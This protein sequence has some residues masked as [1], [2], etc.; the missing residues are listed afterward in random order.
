MPHHYV[1]SVCLVALCWGTLLPADEYKSAREAYSVGAAFYNAGSYAKS[2][3]PF[4]AAIA[5]DEEVKFRVDCYRA[6]IASYRLLEKGD[7]MTTAVEYILIHSE[8]P[9]EKSLTQRSYLSFLHQRGLTE[10]AVKRYEERLKTKP[11]DVIAISILADIYG[12]LNENPARAAELTKQ[13]QKL[14]PADPKDPLTVLKQAELA[15]QLFKAKKYKEAAELYENIAPLDPKLAAWHLKEA[16]SCW[17][18]E[19]DLVRAKEDALA[20]AKSEPE[21]RNDQLTYFWSRNLA[22]I[23]VTTGEFELAVKHYELALTK[24]TI[25]GY[26]KDTKSKLEEAKSK[27]AKP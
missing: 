12:N 3:A 25:D 4:E 10:D 8:R 26:L 9:A 11:E 21:S 15:R 27:L 24:T 23:L 5:L 13:L 18:L 6:L 20:S 2:Q 14:V 7:K 19:K 1:V 22:D 17:L 16:A